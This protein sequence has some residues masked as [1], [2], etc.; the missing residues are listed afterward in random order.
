MSPD[1]HL[2]CSSGIV[3]LA[4]GSIFPV[5][6]LYAVCHCVYSSHLLCHIAWMLRMMLRV[7]FISLFPSV[8]F[9]LRCLFPIEELVYDMV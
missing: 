2:V 5:S 3:D 9:C 1:C 7:M 6:I 8:S 4:T